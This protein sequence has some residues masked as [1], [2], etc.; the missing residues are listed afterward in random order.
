MS[1]QVHRF[2]DRVACYLG[3][4]TTTY[5]TP[6]EAFALAEALIDAAC[7]IRVQPDFCKSEFAT[8]HIPIQ[9]HKER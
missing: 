9:S 1:A 5:L 7:D 8:T 3:S 2:N 4:P 6:D